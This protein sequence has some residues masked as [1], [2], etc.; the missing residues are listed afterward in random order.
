M[1]FLLFPFFHFHFYRFNYYCGSAMWK[2]HQDWLNFSF[3]FLSFFLGLMTP[4]S[5]FWSCYTHGVGS[6]AL[7]IREQPSEGRLFSLR[8]P[9]VA[10]FLA[11]CVPKRSFAVRVACHPATTHVC[12]DESG[13]G[14]KCIIVPLIQL[15]RPRSQWAM[16][17]ACH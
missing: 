8:T 14:K 7:N 16:R 5:L 12:L 3:F 9:S 17:A 6:V 11:L 2:P 15:L 1:A 4:V 13:I 10:R